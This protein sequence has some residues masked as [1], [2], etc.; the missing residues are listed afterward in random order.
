MTD[1][2]DTFVPMALEMINE[3]GK[4]V[5]WSRPAA[6]AYDPATGLAGDTTPETATLKAWVKAPDPK[7]FPDA[8]IGSGDRM[9]LIAGAAIASIE[10]SDV[11]TIDG[12]DYT[13]PDRGVAP[14]YSGEAI[15]LYKVLAS[16]A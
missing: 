9:L 16:Y 15:C 1:F 14:V 11:F 10:P 3:V 13:V 2:D 6:G 8:S 7:A 5:G 12:R 4:S